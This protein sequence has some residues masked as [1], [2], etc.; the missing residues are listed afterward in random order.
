[1]ASQC[2]FNVEQ[3]KFALRKVQ[4]KARMKAQIDAMVQQK[5]RELEVEAEAEA[6]A[7]L[8]D[9]V[10]AATPPALTAEDAQKVATFAR[11][12]ERKHPKP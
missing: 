4:A 1:M 12:V 5:M 2:G 11:D 7:K 9:Q 8:Q 6:K 3:D 10:T